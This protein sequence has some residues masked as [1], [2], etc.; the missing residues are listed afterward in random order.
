M[1]YYADT[2]LSISMYNGMTEEEQAYVIKAIG[3]F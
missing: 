2:V 1:E 3:Y